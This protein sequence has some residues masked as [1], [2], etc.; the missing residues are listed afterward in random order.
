MNK[1]I[2]AVL[3]LGILWGLILTSFAL[4]NIFFAK[5]EAAVFQPPVPVKEDFS[6]EFNQVFIQS[7]QALN[8]SSQVTV[9]KGGARKRAIDET[10]QKLRE[11]KEGLIDLMKKDPNL[12]WAIIY[13]PA[14]LQQIPEELQNEV[15]QP[16]TTRGEIN[17]IHQDDFERGRS[18]FF[19][20]LNAP[21]QPQNLPLYIAGTAPTVL[22][23]S[24][25][26]VHGYKIDNNLLANAQGGTVTVIRRAK[27]EALGNQRVL[28]VLLNFSDS[29]KPPFSKSQAKKL[30]FD[31]R[32]E[33]FVEENSYN[34]THL[35]GEVTDWH[36][37]RRK[38]R[39]ATSASRE[40]VLPEVD[41]IYPLI[42][43]KFNLKDYDRL[44]FIIDYTTQSGDCDLTRGMGEIG[45]WSYQFGGVKYRFSGAWIPLSPISLKEGVWGDSPFRDFDYALSHELGHNLGLPHAHS[46]DCGAVVLGENCQ[47]VEY[48]NRFDTMGYGTNS[49]HFNA[50]Y[51]E[52]LGWL[53]GESSL[54]INKPGTYS[55][56]PLEEAKGV[57]LAK[58]E[59]AKDK[60]T[61]FYLEYRRGIG[62]DKSLNNSRLSGN[63]SGLFIN[64]V[65]PWA[66]F[67]RLLNITPLS[68]AGNEDWNVVTLPQDGQ[69]LEDP[70]RG[71]RIGPVR[72]ADK[73]QITFEVG[74]SDP[75]CQRL[76]PEILGQDFSHSLHIAPG[77]RYLSGFSILNRDWAGC[78]ISK[79]ETLMKL[80]KGWKGGLFQDNTHI[81][82]APGN[83]PAYNF[84]QYLID[85]PRD[86]K[87]GDYIIK[88]LVNNLDSGLKEELSLVVKVVKP[89]SSDL[90][91]GGT[92]GKG[93]PP[94]VKTEGAPPLPGAP[95]ETPPPTGEAPTGG[96]LPAES[97]VAP[98]STPESGVAP[99]PTAEP[100]PVVP[101]EES[102]VAAKEAGKPLGVS[103][104][105][106]NFYK[107]VLGIGALIALL[108]L[109][110][111]GIVYTTSA[112]NESRI[113]EAKEW[114]FGA[115]IGLFLLFGSYLVLNTINPELAKLK[116]ITLLINQSAKDS[117]KPASSNPS[118]PPVDQSVSLSLPLPA[119]LSG[120]CNSCTD[121]STIEGIIIKNNKLANIEVAKKLAI[122]AK[123]TKSNSNLSW[124]VT[125]AFPPTSPHISQCHYDGTC[126]D[127]ALLDNPPTCAQVNELE[128]I[129]QQAGFVIVNEYSG[130]GGTQFSTTTGGHL[131]IR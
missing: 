59:L 102:A 72:T 111:G 129:V 61:P 23:G 85:V 94:A 84:F 126:V 37:L 112:G 118:P 78:E 91:T 71:I 33:A 66:G 108:V 2:W 19:Y 119:A 8:L 31:D 98:S 79:F 10:R 32:V 105:I 26:E 124:R 76:S 16:I 9:E 90:S 55:L 93:A 99:A 130:C 123:L 44:I 107:W 68:P 115:L 47:Q 13:P 101:A 39:I 64:L 110:Y 96:S 42:K 128:R 125:E 51:K 20:Y 77:K 38:A 131:H 30:V 17:V 21:D 6:K 40:C 60:N 122:L 89:G 87:L 57:R 67:S 50:F 75:K 7:E 127:I 48:G 3:V 56:N 116:D 97:S 106:G 95:R 36:T 86:A 104:L 73:R 43:D 121:I 65:P 11:R 81:K 114:V 53:G 27:P 100:S 29:G 28:V 46:W 69:V 1:K 54:I 88:F 109:I 4:Y 74:F 113:G 25:V 45:K 5:E 41:E 35:T 120:G 34:K 52:A 92:G 82:L 62:F 83:D 63:Q 24:E 18:K 58:I 49:S 80:P 70:S 15:E 22:S 117:N 14:V 12:A 103:G